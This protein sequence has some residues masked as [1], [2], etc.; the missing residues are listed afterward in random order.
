MHG[1]FYVN[2]GLKSPPTVKQAID[3]IKTTQEALMVEGNLKLHKI[4]SNREEG[5]QAIFYEDLSKDLKD[6][7]FGNES[8]ST[9]SCCS[10]ES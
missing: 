2:N 9:Q 3:L 7:E 5:M 1:N 6:L 4:A 10:F 8:S